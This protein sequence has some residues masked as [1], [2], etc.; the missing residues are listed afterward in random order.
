MMV[1]SIAI[2]VIFVVVPALMTSGVVPSVGAVK[3]RDDAA[4][5]NDGSEK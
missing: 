4:A 1:V 5:Q 3:R 2:V